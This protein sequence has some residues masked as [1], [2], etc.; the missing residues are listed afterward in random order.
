[1]VELG[2]AGPE[3]SDVGLAPGVGVEEVTIGR[4]ACG[5]ETLTVPPQAASSVTALADQRVKRFN[6]ALKPTGPVP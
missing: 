4:E 3:D 6:L 2:T 5:L 1:M